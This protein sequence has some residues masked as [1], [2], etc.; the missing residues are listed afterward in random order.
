V[1]TGY[2]AVNFDLRG[3][4]NGSFNGERQ[5]KL[6]AI[7]DEV[8]DGG[9]TNKWQ[10]MDIMKDSMTPDQI[11]IKPKYGHEYYEYNCCRWLVFSNHIEALA[12]DD[13]DRRFNVIHNTKPVLSQAYYSKLYEARHNPHF[14]A[15]VHKLLRERDISNFNPGAPAKMAVIAGNLSEIDEMLSEIS[16]A[17]PS[18]IIPQNWLHQLCGTTSD[19]GAMKHALRRA[20]F[21]KYGH[22]VKLYDHRSKPYIIRNAA[23]WGC[24]CNEHVAAEIMRANC[25]PHNVSEFFSNL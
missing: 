13:K 22:K 16:R 21:T 18:D 8:R 24:L 5:R 12:L 25:P 7:V 10:N 4:F 19:T 14:I 17:W 1:W 20:D 9:N 6:I 11:R 23:K 2:A 3:M 15:G